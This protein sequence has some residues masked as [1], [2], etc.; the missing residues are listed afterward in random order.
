MICKLYDQINDD[1]C[2]EYNFCNINCFDNF[3]GLLEAL[4]SLN[5]TRLSNNI[6]LTIQDLLVVGHVSKDSHK[7]H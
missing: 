5:G 4:H 2:E 6:L 1:Y 7:A 3:V